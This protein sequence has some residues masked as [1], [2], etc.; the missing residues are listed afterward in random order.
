MQWWNLRNS[1]AE[2]TREWVGKYVEKVKQ[3]VFLSRE[4]GTGCLGLKTYKRTSFFG[5]LLVF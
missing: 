1:V 4:Q 5:K 3:P 2:L